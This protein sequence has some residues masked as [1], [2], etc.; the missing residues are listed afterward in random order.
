[1]PSPARVATGGRARPRRADGHVARIRRGDRRLERAE[2][3]SLDRPSKLRCSGGRG[4]GALG[5]A[6]RRRELA[7]Y[8]RLHL[9]HLAWRPGGNTSLPQR[10]AIFSKGSRSSWPVRRTDVDDSVWSA[11]PPPM[12]SLYSV[13]FVP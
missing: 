5:R 2:D 3:R 8:A 6:P 1:R 11:P 4:E 13:W 10:S 12:M 9:L 7:P